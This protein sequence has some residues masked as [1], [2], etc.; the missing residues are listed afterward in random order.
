MASPPKMDAELR[1][2][3]AGDKFLYDNEVMVVTRGSWDLVNV[4]ASPEDEP[5]RKVKVRLYQGSWCSI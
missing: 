3:V 5:S 2:P 1:R 4:F